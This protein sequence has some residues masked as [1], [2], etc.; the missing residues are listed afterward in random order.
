M[1]E[2]KEENTKVKMKEKKMKFG[3]NMMRIG[4]INIDGIYDLLDWVRFFS[5]LHLLWTVTKCSS[6][7]HGFESLPEIIY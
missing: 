5:H 2:N 4:S 6:E 1:T 3:N 7:L